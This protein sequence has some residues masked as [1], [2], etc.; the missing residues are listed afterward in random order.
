MS[1]YIDAEPLK[2]KLDEWR[3]GLWLNCGSNDDYVRCLSIVIEII[4]SE[5][6]ADV[7]EVTRCK[8]CVYCEEYVYWCKIHGSNMPRNGFCWCGERRDG[9]E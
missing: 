6:T 1:K 5:P 4:N 9:A 8:D 7:V 2:K 3:C